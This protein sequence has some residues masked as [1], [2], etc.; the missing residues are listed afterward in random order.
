MVLTSTDYF[1]DTATICGLLHIG[2]NSTSIDFSEGDL[3]YCLPVIEGVVH[4]FLLAQDLVAATP[5]AST[6][7]GHNTVKNVLLGLLQIWNQ[8]RQGNKIGNQFES[9]GGG[10]DF[11]ALTEPM[12]LSLI[13]AFKQQ[14]QEGIDTISIGRHQYH[15]VYN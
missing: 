7:Q 2:T 14:D 4:D 12:M 3:N 9:L 8:R 5:V 1:A 10:V 13:M 15:E 11:P 6:T